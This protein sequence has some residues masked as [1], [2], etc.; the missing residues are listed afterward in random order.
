MDTGSALKQKMK[1]EG[2]VALVTGGASGFGK[3][4]A[5]ALLEKGARVIDSADLSNMYHV[6]ITVC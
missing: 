3:G 5:I 6:L 1:I 2:I 4:F